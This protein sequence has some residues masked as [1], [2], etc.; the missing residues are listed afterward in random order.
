[1]DLADK[2]MESMPSALETQIA[3]EETHMGNFRKIYPAENYEKFDAFF[4]QTDNSI[5]QETLASRARKENAVQ[6]KNEVFL[7]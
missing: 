6:Q 5:F 7:Q 2:V 3:W 4:M 1:M